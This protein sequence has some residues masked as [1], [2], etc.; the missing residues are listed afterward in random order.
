LTDLVECNYTNNLDSLITLL[1]PV[2]I[3]MDTSFCAGA[4]IVFLDSTIVSSGDY[5][6]QR[7]LC[8]TTFILHVIANEGDTIPVS[9]M[10]CDGDSILFNGNWL[11]VSGTYTH[12]TVNQFGCDS[13]NVLQL[14]V[15]DH[16][17]KQQEVFLCTGDSI[18]IFD[19]WIYYP[20]LYI[21]TIAGIM[22]DTIAGTTVLLAATYF[23]ESEIELCPGDSIWLDNHWVKNDET[24]VVSLSSIH[25]CD[26]TIISHVIVPAKPNAPDLSIDCAQGSVLAS[27]NADPSWMYEWNNGTTDPSTTY[28]VSGPAYLELYHPPA[29]TIRY[30][31]IVPAIPKPLVLASLHDTFLLED[32]PLHI[33]LGLDPQ[34][35]SV[36]WTPSA[37]MSCPVCLTT[38]VS[39]TSNTSIHVQ[40]VHSSGC[41]YETNFDITLDAIVELYIPNVFS[42]NGDQVN[43]GWYIINPGDKIEIVAAT[44]FDR[45]GNL[46]KEWNNT[47]DIVWDGFFR[48]KAMNPGVFTCIVKYLDQEKKKKVAKG[49]ITLLR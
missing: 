3:E 1:Q 6:F 35:W 2:T 44:I 34:E 23:E 11:K 14:V 9:S 15:E 18:W 25:G 47:N 16:I 31:F 8:D 22:C 13:L 48:G 24:V 41:V 32:H 26:S 46:I 20:G 38:I 37:I 12:L 30:D 36:V 7:G 28:D 17:S 21:D 19:R 10:I 27:G 39:P 29:C 40:L 5:E 43:D 45:W 4:T 42:P 33:T 49:N